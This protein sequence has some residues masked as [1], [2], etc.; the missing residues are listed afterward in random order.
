[1]ADHTRRQFERRDGRVHQR[2]W[3]RPNLSRRRTRKRLIIELLQL[4]CVTA[5]V[6]DSTQD[7]LRCTVQVGRVERRVSLGAKRAG[8]I[9]HRASHGGQTGRHAIAWIVG[10][11]PCAVL[12]GSVH[13][14]MPGNI[15]T[16]SA[17]CTDKS[18]GKKENVTLIGN[19]SQQAS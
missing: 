16:S 14:F 8:H 10:S 1:M 13:P 12:V 7:M 3:C 11:R 9:M 17:P 5:E 15:A 4:L 18:I 19:L 2:C 6:Y